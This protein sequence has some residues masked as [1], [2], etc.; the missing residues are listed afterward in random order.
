MVRLFKKQQGRCYLCN[1]EMEIQ[2][3][4]RNT[5]TIDHVYPLALGG[6]DVSENRRAACWEC[7]NKKANLTLTEYRALKA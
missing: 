2:H 6:R 7:N 4:R 3:G 1:R 5:P